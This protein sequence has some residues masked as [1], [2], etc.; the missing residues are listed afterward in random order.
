MGRGVVLS[1]V[2][3][4][5][6]LLSTHVTLLTRACRYFHTLSNSESMLEVS[7]Y[8]SVVEKGSAKHVQ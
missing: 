1:T 8:V 4:V 5:T 2:T 7:R 6:E 3:M